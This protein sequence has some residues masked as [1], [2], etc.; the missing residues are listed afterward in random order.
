MQF[1]IRLPK[2]VCEVFM[3]IREHFANVHMHITSRMS[4]HEQFTKYY[5]L[6]AKVCDLGG[7]FFLQTTVFLFS[8]LH[9]VRIRKVIFDGF[10]MS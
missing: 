4:V 1:T 6:L 9:M 3:N 7:N 5:E 8:A 2:I 10:S